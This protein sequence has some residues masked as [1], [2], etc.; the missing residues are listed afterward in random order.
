MP[1]NG[2]VAHHLKI[3]APVHRS[4]GSKNMF[5]DILCWPTNVKIILMVLLHYLSKTYELEF[6]RNT[7]GGL[8]GV[9]QCLIK[10]FDKFRM[11]WKH[12]DA[13]TKE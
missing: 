5:F 10:F 7:L 9:T 1:Y 4:T 2:V 12:A 6:N 8:A 11:W 13:F 3:S